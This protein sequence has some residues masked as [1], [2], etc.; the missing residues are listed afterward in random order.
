M[1]IRSLSGKTSKPTCCSQLDVSLPSAVGGVDAAGVDPF[2]CPPHIP[3]K[4]RCISLHQEDGEEFRPPLKGLILVAEHRLSIF[5]LVDEPTLPLL[6]PV[7]RH[8][9]DPL[10]A[11]CPVQDTA[12][13]HI[14]AD[15][16][17]GERI[18]ACDF[19]G[20][21]WTRKCL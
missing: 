14:L 2:V 21:A 17:H 3:Q 8:P 20:V 9:G 16:G 18:E 7:D 11:I 13:E 12:E 6:L 1:T 5:V 4:Q 19:R 10:L 15:V